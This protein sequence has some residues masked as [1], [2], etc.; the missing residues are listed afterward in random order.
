M[1]FVFKPSST[2]LD[3]FKNI[4]TLIQNKKPFGYVT[5]TIV[6][7]KTLDSSGVS[8]FTFGSLPFMDAVFTPLK[9]YIAGILWFLYFVYWYVR[10]LKHLDI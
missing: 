3:K 5:A 8:L 2:A 1:Q 4:W 6:Q 7:L 10:R 9:N